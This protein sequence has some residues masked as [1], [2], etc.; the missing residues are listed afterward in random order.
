MRIG[1]NGLPIVE[2]DGPSPF[3]TDRAD[4]LMELRLVIGVV[5]VVGV[6]AWLSTK[7][8][9]LHAAGRIFFSMWLHELGHAC[10]AWF[11]GFFALP[12]PWRTMVG[13]ERSFG[14]VV[15]LSVVI[16]GLAF[17][18]HRTER[19]PLVAAA[20][21]LMGLQVWGH[22]VSVDKARA[23]I[24]FFG[25]GGCMVIGAL[26]VARFFAGPE[27][28][29]LTDDGPQ[30]T[31]LRWGLVVIGAFALADASSVWWAARADPGEIPFGSIEGV[32]L[33]DPSVLVDKF[34]WT[35]QKLVSRYVTTSTLCLLLVAVCQVMG[36]RRAWLNWR[37]C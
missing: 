30:K 27:A 32:G 35:E 19:R 11:T 20:A 2:D 36:V 5:P 26:L 37:D 25:D 28:Q 29:R 16:A 9:A 15:A 10:A 1:R 6:L 21:V 33:S 13:E 8:D 22:V 7:S 31:W 14:V 24:S 18:G 12:G 17:Y 23:F 4:A 34:H 3:D